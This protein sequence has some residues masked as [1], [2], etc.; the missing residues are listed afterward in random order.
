MRLIH[1]EREV[2]DILGEFGIRPLDLQKKTQEPYFQYHYIFES[3]PRTI[4]LFPL[5]K[6][7]ANQA[8][9]LGPCIIYVRATTIWKGQD[10]YLA[11]SVISNAFSNE[12][13]SLKDRDWVFVGK[14]QR[15]KL[16]SLF[17]LAMQF[18]WDLDCYS[19]EPFRQFEI[20]H[21]GAIAFF[22]D[23]PSSDFEERF[24]AETGRNL[25]SRN[26]N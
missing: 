8:L 4:P 25:A 15:P 3:E 10:E 7:C 17:H 14:D 1:S 12:V 18:G 20:D 5:A 16:A 2:R 9:Q 6:F 13:K 23:K 24:L 21:D 22:L 26:A 11:E 19:R